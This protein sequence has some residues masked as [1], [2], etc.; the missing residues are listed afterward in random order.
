MPLEMLPVLPEIPSHA[1]CD[2]LLVPP[3]IP[4]HQRGSDPVGDSG[5]IAPP[6]SAAASRRP[7]NQT[8][9][10]T[11]RQRRAWPGD[12]RAHCSIGLGDCG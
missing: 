11:D 5:K 2:W 6:S 7:G 4:Q 12:V 3:S 1:G 10:K 9:E 8:A